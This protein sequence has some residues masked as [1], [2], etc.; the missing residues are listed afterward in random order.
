MA[1]A[2][3]QPQ[4]VRGTLAC[5]G[6]EQKAPYTTVTQFT[7]HKDLQGED[8]IVGCGTVPSTKRGVKLNLNHSRQGGKWGVPHSLFPGELKKKK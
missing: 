1:V 3:P 2:T 8:E 4:H 6:C 7:A 5:Y